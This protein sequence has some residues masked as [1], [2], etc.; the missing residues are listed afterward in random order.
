MEFF[1]NTYHSYFDLGKA[2][3]ITTMADDGNIDYYIIGGSSLKGC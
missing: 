3:S 2:I 1:D